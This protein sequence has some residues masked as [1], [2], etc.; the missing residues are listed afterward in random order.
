MRELPD[1]LGAIGAVIDEGDH[2]VTLLGSLSPSYA[3]IGTVL[4]T[5]M[6][7]MTLQF[8]HQSLVNEGQKRVQAND[9]TSCAAAG[10]ASAITTQGEPQPEGLDRCKH[11]C[12]KCGKGGHLKHN[13]PKLKNKTHR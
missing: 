2:I 4:E 9:S 11:K 5:K 6:D 12:F 8:V 10:G 13:C 1:Q 3:T 7:S